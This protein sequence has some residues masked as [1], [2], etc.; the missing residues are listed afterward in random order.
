MASP[1]ADL[2]ATLVFVQA[3]SSDDTTGH[4]R[5]ANSLSQRWQS[6]GLTNLPVLAQ[7]IQVVQSSPFVAEAKTVLQE[8]L[9]KFMESA[10]IGSECVYGHRYVYARPPLSPIFFWND[11]S[12]FQ[13]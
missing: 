1:L 8:A 3:M 9:T 4:V 6:H 10:I 12:A 2:K 5:V 13:K 7:M 11:I